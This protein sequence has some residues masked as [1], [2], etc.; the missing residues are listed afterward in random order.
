MMHNK[1]KES[2]VTILLFFFLC[3]IWKK[4]KQ[5]LLL[6]IYNNYVY[7]ILTKNWTKTNVY[8]F[9]AMCV[10]IT[11]TQMKESACKWAKMGWRH[12]SVSQIPTTS[13]TPG[14]DLT[15]WIDQRRTSTAFWWRQS[16]GLCVSVRNV[17]GE[18]NLTT[19]RSDSFSSVLLQPTNLSPQFKLHWEKR[20]K[21]KHDIV[22]IKCSNNMTKWRLTPVMCSVWDFQEYQLS[23]VNDNDKYPVW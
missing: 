12:K 15:L 6:Y 13:L 10:T 21:N 8:T 22:I 7:Y 18:V 3:V 20:R 16:S 19:K 9:P 4:N 5:L 23:C 1:I 11:H 2:S 14:L 17:R